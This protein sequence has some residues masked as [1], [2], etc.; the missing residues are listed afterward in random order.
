[1]EDIRITK[2]RLAILK[3]N[4]NKKINKINQLKQ[5]IRNQKIQY[6]EIEDG[7]HKSYNIK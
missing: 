2:L 6:M 3:G 7:M 4:I 5:E 1:M